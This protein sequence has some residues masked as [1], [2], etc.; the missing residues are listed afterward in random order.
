MPS[1]FPSELHHH[2]WSS[3]LDP[4]GVG[5]HCTGHQAVVSEV[6]PYFSPNEI[7]Q[8]ILNVKD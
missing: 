1:D 3:L 8:H 4:S 7:M 6:W 5:F 2:N